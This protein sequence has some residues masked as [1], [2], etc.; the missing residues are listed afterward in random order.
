MRTAVCAQWSTFKS[1]I[2]VLH[3]VLVMPLLP[4]TSGPDLQIDVFKPSRLSIMKAPQESCALLVRVI[5]KL[6]GH[7]FHGAS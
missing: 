5:I 7:V 4:Y 2:D 6:R 3:S 1:H